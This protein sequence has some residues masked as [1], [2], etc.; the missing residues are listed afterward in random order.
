MKTKFFFIL[1]TCLCFYANAQVVPATVA[2]NVYSNVNTWTGWRHT[3][4]NDVRSG[5]IFLNYFAVSVTDYLAVTTGNN[6]TLFWNGSGIIS[7]STTLVTGASFPDVTL[8]NSGTDIYVGVAYYKKTNTTGAPEGYYFQSGRWISGAFTMNA[9]ILLENTIMPVATN[10]TIH[11]D[12]D[13]T[14]R[15]A[16]V[17]E[18]ATSAVRIRPGNIVGTTPTLGTQ[19]NGG[20]AREP[21]VS[22]VNDGTTSFIN[23]VGINNTRDRFSVRASNWATTLTAFT[24]LYTSPFNTS[25]VLPRISGPSRGTSR[26]F[27]VAVQRNFI[28]GGGINRQNIEMVYYNSGATYRILNTGTIAPFVNTSAEENTMPVITY[29]DNNN[30]ISVQWFCHAP[31]AGINYDL[32][33]I[34]F[35]IPTLALVNTTGYLEV[36]QGQTCCSAPPPQ[37]NGSSTADNDGYAVSGRFCDWTKMST[38]MDLNSSLGLNNL[39]WKLTSSTLNSYKNMPGTTIEKSSVN[40]ISVNP[41]PTSN[42]FSIVGNMEHIYKVCVK[43]IQGKEIYNAEGTLQDVNAKLPSMNKYSNGIYL[44]SVFNV[45]TKELNVEKLIKQ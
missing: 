16:I 7:G 33:G 26:Q 5:G 24:T 45:Q 22:V 13:N 42:S 3:I 4:N 44:V 40:T 11:I 21:D 20:S 2:E 17:W 6:P 18:N 28:D 39:N 12:G 10:P 38:F 31:V 23:I 14:G 43:D 15:F 19:F 29:F 30:R 37:G 32:I 36:N 27:S 9:P 35:F 1:Y 41:N 8:L 34:D 25:Y